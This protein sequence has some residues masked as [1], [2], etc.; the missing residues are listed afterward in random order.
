MQTII[1][2]GLKYRRYVNTNGETKYKLDNIMWVGED[3]KSRKLK[4]GEKMGFWRL[5]KQRFG[6]VKCMKDNKCNHQGYK[7]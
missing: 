6:K 7:I 2:S 3:E 5:K 4:C 1:I